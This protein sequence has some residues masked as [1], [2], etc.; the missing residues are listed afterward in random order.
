MVVLKRCS[1]S[2]FHQ[3]NTLL[4]YLVVGNFKEQFTQKLTT[5]SKSTQLLLMESHCAPTLLLFFIVF[6]N[7]QG[8]NV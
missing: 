4:H 5:Q 1:F 3:L 8:S 2:S 7:K 6:F